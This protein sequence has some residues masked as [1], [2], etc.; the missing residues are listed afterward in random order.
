MLLRLQKY[1]LRV[2][3]KKGQ[4]MIL[5]DTLSRVF[6]PEV[7]TCE[8]T[9][10]LEEVDHRASLPVSQERWQQMRHASVNDPV[11]QQLQASIHRDGQKPDPKFRSAFTHTLT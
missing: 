9:K 2:T 7:N 6:L 3:Y 4:D 10:E 1:S 8:V 5:A 11:L